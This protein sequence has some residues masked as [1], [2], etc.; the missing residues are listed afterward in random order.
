VKKT[1]GEFG[2]ARALLESQRDAGILFLDKGTHEISLANSVTLKVYTSPYTPSKAGGWG[3][4]YDPASPHHWDIPKDIDIA[5]THGPPHGILDRTHEGQRV[6]CPD[7]FSAIATSHLSIA[8][9]T[10]TKAGVRRRLAGV[11]T[12]LVNIHRILQISTM[13]IRKL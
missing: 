9:A 10:S 13:I 5:I 11:V 3:Y 1:Y 6:G 8:S 7:L 2:E 12:N 4:C